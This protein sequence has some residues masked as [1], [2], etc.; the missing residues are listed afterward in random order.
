MSHALLVLMSNLPSPGVYKELR[1]LSFCFSPSPTT[2]HNFFFRKQ[3]NSSLSIMSLFTI[4]PAYSVEAV[5]AIEERVDATASKR[6][7]IPSC[8]INNLFF[9]LV[10]LLLAE[11]HIN[12]LDQVVTEEIRDKSGKGSW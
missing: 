7:L 12:N 11:N 2:S 6:V 4:T 5:K 1:F 3:P 10:H 8:L 9:L